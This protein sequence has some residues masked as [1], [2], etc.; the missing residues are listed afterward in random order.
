[1]FSRTTLPSITAIALAF[2]LTACAGAD[3]S[4]DA[5][6]DDSALGD[7]HGSIAGA[8]ELPEPQLHLLTLDETGALSHLDLLD[9][10]VDELGTV[11]GVADVATEGRYAYLVRP[12]AG[13]VTVVDSGVWTW[14]H[15]DH[16]HY[17]RGEASVLGDVEGSGR[18]TVAAN[19]FG[20]GLFFAETGEAVV[21][22]AAT[23]ADASLDERVRVSV[24]P[25][26]GFIVP[27]GS[28]ALVTEPGAD[29]SPASVRVV[30]GEG[31]LAEA[32]ECANAAG[33][34][35]TVVGVVVGCRDGALL[36][37][38]GDSGVAEI[39]RIPYPAGA[40]AP[41]ATEFRA[42]EGR[43][44]VAAVAGASGIWLLDTRKRSWALIDAGTPI[45][46]ASAVDDTDEHVL[47]LAADGRMLVL[48]GAT[49][50]LLAATEPIVAASAADPELVTGIELIADQHRA[51]LNG[52]AERQLFEIDFAD[53]ARIART[54]DTA[55]EPRFTVETGR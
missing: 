5:A 24:E 53:A 33:T 19:D 34:I 37:T 45:V 30:D 26:D 29:G 41:P 21:L 2:T 3:D 36:A 4:S 10:S 44:T 28:S 18:A 20:A 42:R 49:G 7:G 8:Q 13:A 55:A 32:V 51:Y 14:S 25:H 17:Y 12:D 9:E 38:I 22:D 39:E 31:G 1:M 50:E 40:G 6:G 35:A 54:F 27:V 16:F 47:A 23:L 48:S 15:V 52:P 11:D 43:P 46:Q